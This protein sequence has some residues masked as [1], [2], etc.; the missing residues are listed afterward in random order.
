MRFLDGLL[1][2]HLHVLSHLLNDLTKLL[3]LLLELVN[4]LIFI[5]WPHF[6]KLLF[7]KT[8]LHIWS[9]LIILIKVIDQRVNIIIIEL[10]L[11]EH[12]LLAIG[13]H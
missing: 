13:H 9:L 1:S 2:N 7:R 12:L 5:I 8:P 6:A 3:V 4:L 11:L 10:F